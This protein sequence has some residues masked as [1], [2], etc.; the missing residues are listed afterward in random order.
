M[1]KA[2]KCPQCGETFYRRVKD[3]CPNPSCRQPLVL[4]KGGRVALKRDKERTRNLFDYFST[5]YMVPKNVFYGRPG[6]GAWVQEMV[7]AKKIISDSEVQL[8]YSS[9]S[10]LDPL[11]FAKRVIDFVF[12]DRSFANFAP[13]VCTLRMCNGKVFWSVAHRVLNAIE[14]EESQ[15]AAQAHLAAGVNESIEVMVLG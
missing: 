12:S 6:C 7:F 14:E 8:G 4:E 5:K 1:A 10:D 13:K 11:D 3:C 15:V 2:K 9:R